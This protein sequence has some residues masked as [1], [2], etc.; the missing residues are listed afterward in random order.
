MH[1]T[2]RPLPKDIYTPLPTFFHVDESLDLESLSRHVQYTAMAGCTPVVCGSA[3]EAPHLSCEERIPII[4]T[5]RSA[6]SSITLDHIPVIA[7]VGA[8]STRETIILATQAY[9]AG[10]DYAMAIASGFYASGLVK[11]RAASYQMLF[12]GRSGVYDLIVDVARQSPDIGCVNLTCGSV[13][14][15]VKIN[16]VVQSD[17]FMSLDPRSKPCEC[18]LVIDG[19]IDILLPSIVSGAGGAISG[20][21]N[22]IPHTCNRLWELCFSKPGTPQYAEAQKLQG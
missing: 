19:F 1:S 10:S 21:P 20:L 14:K 7:G 9:S 6:R 11:R 13:G 3:G 18:F 22:L 4:Q 5:A 15:I 17:H 8:P 12:L 16:V 2:S